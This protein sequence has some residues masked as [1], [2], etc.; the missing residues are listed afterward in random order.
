MTGNT[1]S[2]AF[3]HIESYIEPIGLVG[4]LQNLLTLAGQVHH[5]SQF[6]ICRVGEGGHMP[7]ENDHQVSCGVGESIQNEESVLLAKKNETLPIPIR[8]GK[9]AKDAVRVLATRGEVMEAPG[10]PEVVHL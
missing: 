1:C 8:G 4:L 3:P 6:G 2:R 9:E 5:F 10:S 7:V